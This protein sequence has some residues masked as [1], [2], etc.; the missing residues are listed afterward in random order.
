MLYQR[1]ASV[2]TY[3]LSKEPRAA[4]MTAITVVLNQLI[5]ASAVR[6]MLPTF[7]QTR[8]ADRKYPTMLTVSR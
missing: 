8:N 3:P 2:A 1:I 4:V 7:L 6:E 5:E